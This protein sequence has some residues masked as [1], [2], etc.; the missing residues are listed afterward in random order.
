MTTQ[1]LIQM[2]SIG[3]TLFMAVIGGLLTGM[4]WLEIFKVER[5]S[6]FFVYRH[7]P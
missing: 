3:I 2:A 5:N 7:H 4:K 1:A 6:F